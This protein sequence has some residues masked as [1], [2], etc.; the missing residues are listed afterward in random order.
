MDA[1]GLD[2]RYRAIQY[3]EQKDFNVG[4]EKA[5]RAILDIGLFAGA[6]I[7]TYMAQSADRPITA[8]LIFLTGVIAIAVHSGLRNALIAAIAASLFYNFFLTGPGLGFRITSSDELVP[9]VAF[10][11]SA[12]IAGI[13]VGRL[14]DAARRADIANTENAFLLSVSDRLQRAIS[15]SQIESELR[16]VLP[17]RNVSGVEIYLC[18]D[19]R[20]ERPVTGEILDPATIAR[21]GD[22]RSGG[23]A[24]NLC[25]SLEGPQGELGVARFIASD[26]YSAD[27]GATVSSLGSMV[28]ILALAVD[29]CVLLEKVADSQAS[30][31]GEELKDAILSSISH[32]LRTPLT[33]IETAASALIA[34]QV[35]LSQSDREVLVHSIIEQCHRLDRYTCELLD[36]GKIQ[37]GISQS[38]LESVELSEIVQTA[39]KHALTTFP[40]VQFDRSISARPVFV[41]ANAVMLEQAI[42][43]VIEN[44]CKFGGEK[45]P[46][47]VELRPHG[48]QALIRITDA[49]PGIAKADRTRIFDRFFR[50]DTTRA[51]R[52]SGLGLYIARG[53][54]EAFSG[55]IAV[56]HSSA[57]D[58]A[59]IAITLPLASEPEALKAMP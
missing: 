2:T 11:I 43:N 23:A 39:I 5:V 25:F 9:L 13:L 40:K 33:A 49:G 30:Q 29:R 12:V 44:A 24:R 38:Q 10:N 54:V 26:G 51:R 7:L 56:E 15:V 52:G 59:T 27:T 1:L 21:A 28:S 32:D 22:S 16:M 37:S 3:R 31:R 8:V 42:F 18:I 35:N 45:G 57:S 48:A 53:F 4:K 41:T 14:K 47:S 19:G 36:I 20:Y 50:S 17:A 58:G 6:A 34:S 55:T 46:V